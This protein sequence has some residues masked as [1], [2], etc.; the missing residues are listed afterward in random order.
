LIAQLLATFGPSAVQLIDSLITKIEAN[1]TV[2]ADEWTT[3]R[4]SALQ[5]A[6]DRMLG[7][8]KA[9]GIDPA[10]PQGV[11]LLAAAA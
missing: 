3:L 7:Q 1:G 8:L 6:K 2:T 5:T 11:A 4:T 10:S 9:A